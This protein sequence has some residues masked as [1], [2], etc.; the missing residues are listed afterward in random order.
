MDG[1]KC[2]G[3]EKSILDCNF[4]KKSDCG[5]AE[6]VGVICKETTDL[7]CDPVTVSIVSYCHPILKVMDQKFRSKGVEVQQWRVH[8]LG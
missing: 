7:A 3:E 6:W 1:L 5:S 2:T 8:W 4:S